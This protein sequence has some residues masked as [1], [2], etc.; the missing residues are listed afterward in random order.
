M[1][2]APPLGPPPPDVER[3]YFQP[4]PLLDPPALGLPGW[5]GD[6]EVAI[7]KPHLINQ[8]SL[9]VT[10]PD[11]SMTQVGV[12]ASHL[13]WT[14]SPRVELG[15]RLPSG[16]GGIAV[17]YRC[18]FAQGSDA[19]IGADGPATLHSRLDYHIGDVDWVSNEYTPWHVCD[20]RVR[21]GLRY[22]NSYFDSQANE[23]FAEA[24]VGTTIYQQRTTDHLWVFGPHVGV[25]LR[26]RLDFGGLAVLGRLD[27]SEGWGRVSQRYFASSTTSASG[28]PQ[29]AQATIGTSDAVPMPRANLGLSWQPA[30]YPNAFLFVGAQ[31]DY[32]W[33]TGRT[34]NFTTY[35]YFFDSGISIQAAFNF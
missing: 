32:F 21:F 15:Y 34:G 23:P 35:G 17:S 28:A 7:L 2:P 10:F 30:A 6:V 20:M 12:D 13:N 25:D 31:I 22:F 26:R 24:A 1:A 3:P 11:G 5:F 9:P 33:N 4:D 27:L 8:L 14:A 16:F 18:L 19:V 29:S